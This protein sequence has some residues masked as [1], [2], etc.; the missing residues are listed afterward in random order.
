MNLEP[1]LK[2]ILWWMGVGFAV[3]ACVPA[4]VFGQG[5]PTTTHSR[6][7]GSQLIFGLSD[8]FS[9]LDG[10]DHFQGANQRT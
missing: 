6:S 7:L 5:L 4:E 1:T 3:L 8:S 2:K 9:A 10:A